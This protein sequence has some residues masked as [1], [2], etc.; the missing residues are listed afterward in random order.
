MKRIIYF[1]LV[2][3]S[4]LVITGCLLTGQITIVEDVNIG[5][6]TNGNISVFHLNLNNNEDYADNFDKIKSI[7]GVSFVA[8]IWNLEDSAST[9]KI[10]I[11]SNGSYSTTDLVED[12]AIKIL[13]SP[14]VPGNDSILIGWNDSYRY[15][16]NLDSLFHYVKDVGEFYVYAIASPVPFH[17]SVRAQIVITMTVGN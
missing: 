13:E 5:A 10:Y 6:T 3:V 12:N 8:K 1:G 2:A 16:H 7:D 15:M 4:G 14:A 9:A 11:S 17:D